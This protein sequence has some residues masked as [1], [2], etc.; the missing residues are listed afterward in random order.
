MGISFIGGSLVLNSGTD[1]KLYYSMDDK[2]IAKNVNVCVNGQNIVPKYD[3]NVM[4]VRVPDISISSLGDT[5]NVKISVNGKDINQKYSV[6]TYMYKALNMKNA[7]AKLTNV[8]KALYLYNDAAKQY[9][10]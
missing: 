6:M 1:L 3:G 10:M 4:C 9:S 5:Y 2:N 8:I 7:D